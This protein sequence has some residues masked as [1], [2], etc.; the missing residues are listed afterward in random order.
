MYKHTYTYTYTQNGPKKIRW[1]QNYIY[2]RS[3][4]FSDCLDISFGGSC[5]HVTTTFFETISHYVLYITFWFSF[6]F[7]SVDSLY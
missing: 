6:V 5:I 1:P 4:V 7:A 2:T 3:E